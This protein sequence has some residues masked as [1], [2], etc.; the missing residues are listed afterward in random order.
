VASINFIHIYDRWGN[1]IHT[2]SSL[3]PNPAGAGNWDGTSNGKELN[4]GVYVYVASITFIDNN[5]TLVYRGDITL[6]K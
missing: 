3:L 6:L 5:T 2:E 1:L 4:P